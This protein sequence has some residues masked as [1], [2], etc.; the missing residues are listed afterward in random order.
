M[1]LMTVRTTKIFCGVE[2]HLGEM[3]LLPV[4]SI[5]P[6]THWNSLV[7]DYE[8][9]E[10]AHVFPNRGMHS[11]EM[12]TDDN[13]VEMSLCDCNPDHEYNPQGMLMVTHRER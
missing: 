9:G 8:E 13:G 2:I 10:V 11:E 6:S 1:N 12:W 3:H 7:I 5:Y 4:N